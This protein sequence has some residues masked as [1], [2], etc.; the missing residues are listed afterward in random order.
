MGLLTKILARTIVALSKEPIQTR[1]LKQSGTSN[2]A[3]VRYASTYKAAVLKE[4]GQPLVIEDRPRR[5]LNKG[6]ARIRVY[7][8]GINSIDQLTVSGDM[9]PAPQLPVVPGYEVCGELLEC[10]DEGEDCK[11]LQPGQRVIGMHPD[12]QGGF[13][14]EI[15][16]S[17]KVV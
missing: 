14:E 17:S 2:F 3:N 7:C 11:L 12:Y 1:I 15:I 6:E 5:T 8:C 16:I 10:N 13:A 4:I 9:D